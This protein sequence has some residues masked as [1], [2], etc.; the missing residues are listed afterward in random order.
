MNR[1]DPLS[2]R[3]TQTRR[4]GRRRL[5]AR[6]FV[7]AT[8][9]LAGDD[10]FPSR[11][12]SFVDDRLPVPSAYRPVGGISGADL[13]AFLAFFAA[14]FSFRLLVFCFRSSLCDSLPMTGLLSC[15][16]TRLTGPGD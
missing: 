15:R 12:S 6:L 14:R 16:A 3:A 1:L 13:D 8:A 11:E 9:A 2:R 5:S 10:A 4:R 7:A